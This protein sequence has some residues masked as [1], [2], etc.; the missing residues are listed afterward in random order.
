MGAFTVPETVRQQRVI[1]VLNGA[2]LPAIEVTSGDAMVY[3]ITLPLTY[4]RRENILQFKLPDAAAPVD[5]GLGA[6]ERLLGVR[7]E[8]F[9][10]ARQK[11]ARQ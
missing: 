4:L 2:E 7:V 3:G 1:P 11:P 8:W 9:E 5:L 10:I 6:D